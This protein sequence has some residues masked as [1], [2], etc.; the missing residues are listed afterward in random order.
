MRKS[1]AGL[2]ALSTV[3]LIAAGGFA[4]A[5]TTTGPN[6]ETAVPASS[7]TLTAEEEAKI[8]EGNYTAGLAWH[9]PSDYT[10]AVDKGA[11]DEFARLGIEVVAVSDAGFDAAKQKN[12]VETMMAKSPTIILSLPVDP[13]TASE[14]YRPALE[15]GTKVAFVDNA[16]TGYKQGTDYVTIVSDD[17]Y[18]MG[19]KAADAHG[20][21]DRQ[22]G[23]GRLS[24]P[25]RA[26]STSPT[27]A[28]APSRRRSRPNI[29]TSRSSRRW[30]SPIPPRRKT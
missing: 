18:Q 5:G 2:T 1:L 21:G 9:T 27:S 14:V 22:Q 29:P 15:A 28:T 12:D 3:L 17:L 8:R 23:Q 19:E 10:A 25:R 11:Q 16:P 6:G 20:R 13:D 4:V 7:V 30:G 24:V 26:I